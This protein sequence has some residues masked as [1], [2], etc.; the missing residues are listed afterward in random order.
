MWESTIVHDVWIWDHNKRSIFRLSDVRAFEIK[1]PIKKEAEAELIAKMK[2]KSEHI[3]MY[4][5]RT[6]TQK[7]TLRC[8]EILRAK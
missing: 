4:S 3:I 7:L 1:V 2:D 5:Q 6:D 8:E